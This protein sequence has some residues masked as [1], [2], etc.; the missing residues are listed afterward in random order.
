[1][2]F[3]TGIVGIVEDGKTNFYQI[4]SK[5]KLIF[6]YPKNEALENSWAVVTLENREERKDLEKVSEMLKKTKRI[7]ISSGHIYWLKLATGAIDAYLDPFGGERLYEMFACAVAQKNGCIVSD[8][9]GKYFDPIENLKIFE[10]NQDYI[11]YPVAAT[12]KVL[13]NEILKGIK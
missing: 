3:Q 7:I 4:Q 2:D 8:L 6:D 10:S 11:Y 13:H 1:M 12:N 9:T 5:E